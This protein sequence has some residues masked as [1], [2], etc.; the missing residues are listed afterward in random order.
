MSTVTLGVDTSETVSNRFVAGEPQ[1]AYITFAS[2]DLLFRTLTPR[3]WNILRSMTG[4]GPLSIAEL[5]RHARSNART[6]RRDVEAL[7][8]VGVLERH[9]DGTV[10]FPYDAVH[11]DF[12]LG[13]S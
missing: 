7:L 5:T 9:A 8:D 3:R 13:S 1:G 12:L 11:V 6:V 10:V 4:A 2:A